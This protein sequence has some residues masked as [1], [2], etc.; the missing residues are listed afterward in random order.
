MTPLAPIETLPQST[1]EMPVASNVEQVIE[2]LEKVELKDEQPLQ[3]T[4]NLD[5]SNQSDSNDAPED[6]NDNASSDE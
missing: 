4:N 3:P 1:D 2:S 6:S 5:P